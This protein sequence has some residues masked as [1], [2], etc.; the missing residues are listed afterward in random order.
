MT[1][2]SRNEQR[3]VTMLQ[4]PIFLLQYGTAAFRDDEDEDAPVVRW[5][6]ERVFATQE[7]ATA[8]GKAHS[9]NYPD[10]WRTWSVPCC[11]QL[12]EIMNKGLPP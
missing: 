8:Y 12:V 7:E 10:G 5:T 3:R 2:V 11:G 9:Y 1:A 4:E 6:T